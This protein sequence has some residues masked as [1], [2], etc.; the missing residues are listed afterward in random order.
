[1]QPLDKRQAAIR[2]VGVKK[3]YGKGETRVEALKGIDLEVEQGKL[4][5]LVGPSGSGKTTLL[6]I[7]T[8][9]L[10]PDEGQVF[11]LGQDTNSMSEEER[12]LF[13]RANLGIVFQSLFLIP[14]L[15]ASENV[16]VPLLVAGYT[17]EAARVKAM[18]ILE[19]MKISHHAN[20]S[21][22]F[23]SRGEQQRISIARAMVNDSQIIVCDEPTSA[24]DQA[25]GM[26]V[27]GLLHDLA[28]NASKAVI[29]VTHDHRTFPFA[30]K[31][32]N[33]SDGQIIP[34][35]DHA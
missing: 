28:M 16:A 6:S 20:I 25:S 5:L 15:T 27:M 11:L 18:D 3:A 1:M 22:L 29:V 31:I 33:M 14:S 17:Q 2:C 32:V 24:L 7:I 30:D 34:G 8:H 26:A 19:R 9:I 21:P 13:C 10:T 4:T 12:T 35:E 23:L